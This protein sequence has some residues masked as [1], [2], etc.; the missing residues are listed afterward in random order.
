MPV[1]LVSRVDVGDVQLANGFLKNL[2]G[3]DDGNRAAG[4]SRGVDDDCVGALP[5]RLNEL[6]DGSFE[7]R[8]MERELDAQVVSKLAA[9]GLNHLERCVSINMRFADSEVIEIGSVDN[10]QPCCHYYLLCRCSTP[11]WVLVH[12]TLE[13]RIRTV[14]A[15]HE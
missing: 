8:L 10:H 1:Q 6:D 15:G 2:H 5:T 7:V 3:V 12:P 9:P 14:P 13:F 11:Q 4:I